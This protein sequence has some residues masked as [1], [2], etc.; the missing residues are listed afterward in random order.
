[1]KTTLKKIVS[2]AL[3]VS[4]PNLTDQPLIEINTSKDK[5]HGDFAT[6]IA[7]QLAK[8]LKQAPKKIAEVLCS[9]LD[10]ECISKVE[11][12][13]PGFI[14]FFIN[15]DFKLS[16]LDPILNGDPDFFHP[17]IGQGQAVHLEFVSANPTGP[18]HVGHGRGAAIGS[19]IANILSATGHTVH[20]EYYVND[21]GLQM[22]TLAT[23]LWFRYMNELGAAIKL[24]EKAYQGDYLIP[25]AKTTLKEHNKDFF[26]NPTEHYNSIEEW[27]SA[28]KQ[29]LQPNGFENLKNIAYRAILTTIKED[30]VT[31]NVHYD[32][33][34]HESTLKDQDTLQTT[35]GKIKKTPWAYT[36]NGALWFKAT[37]FG[38]DK[39][40]VLIRSNGAHTYFTADI[41]YHYHKFTQ[42]SG[43]IIDIFGSD[44][45]GY[46]PR[47]KASLQALQCDLNRYK[48]KLVQFATLFRGKEQISMST[49]S[50]EFITLIE[51]INEVGVDAARYYYCSRRADQHVNFDLEIAKKQS[52]DNPVY[53][54][55][56]AHARICSILVKNPSTELIDI[57]ML[58]L[59]S[60]HQ[61]IQTLSQ[62]P[63]KLSKCATLLEPHHLTHYL[64]ELA[65][66]IHS[67]YNQT[68]I[69][70]EN[71]SL[72][73]A[74]I[75]LMIACKK[76][77]AHGLNLLSISAPEKM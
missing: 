38:D 47:V 9:K 29:Q 71:R 18:L 57:N 14:N 5:Q 1:M 77:L 35:L 64:Y 16:Q 52:N 55:Q 20:K 22:D 23:S 61:L 12:A 60:E 30:L 40:R 7:M 51:L 39:D 15:P 41:A 36:D 26:W 43:Q 48:V 70:V 53:Y 50:G 2:E 11:I 76:T 33:W 8:H 68:R 75:G 25:I 37:A 44:H 31:F 27:I 56:Y 10:N 45:H 17:N 58:Q 19:S 46:I 54:I 72:Q 3:L 13:G 74:R 65:G 49:R 63:E 28:L 4:Y 59:P 66:S 24:P 34:F 67:Y 73:S 69:Q 32:S 42:Y 6:N 62:F 21:V